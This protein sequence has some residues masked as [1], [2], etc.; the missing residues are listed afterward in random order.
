MRICHLSSVHS[1][2]DTRIFVKEFTST[3][4]QGIETH[5]VFPGE[6]SDFLND[7]YRHPVSSKTNSKILRML[8]T[9]YKIYKVGKKVNADVYQFHDPEMIPVGLWL[10]KQGKKVIYDVHED[11]PRQILA[12]S[13]IPKSLRRMISYIF[14]K[15]EN[16]ASKRFDAVFTATPFINERF[17]KMKCN[18]TNINNYPLI[19][20]LKHNRVQWT[21]KEK[22]VCYVGEITQVRGSKEMVKSIGLSEHKLLL[23]GKY[24]PKQDRDMLMKLPGWD[25]VIELGFLSRKDVVATLSKSMGGLVILNPT[26]NYIDSLPVKMFEYMAAGIPV[27][28]SNFPLWETIVNGNNCGITVDPLNPSEVAKAIDWVINNPI[29]AEKMGKNG[30][31]AVEKKYNWKIEEAK[32]LHVYKSLGLINRVKK[33]VG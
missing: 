26:I 13:W 9:T 24:A 23:G 18:A 3:K 6:E 28:S 1:G 5:Y 16:F 30:L 11:V 21:K 2:N 29:E 19:S 4:N 32:M 27:I 31:A 15:F 12:K 33:S 20:E 7:P 25:N 14:E 10:K 17:L 8:T 22:V